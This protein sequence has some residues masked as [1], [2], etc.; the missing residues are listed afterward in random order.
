MRLGHQISVLGLIALGY[1]AILLSSGAVGIEV[2]PPFLVSAVI[3]ISSGRLLRGGGR[4][5]VKER[6]ADDEAPRKEPNWGLRTQIL[7]WV[8]AILIF[9]TLGLWVVKPVGVSFF[10]MFGFK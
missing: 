3:F 6:P 5:L 8:M 10:E 1:C 2:L 7:N 4:H 9:C